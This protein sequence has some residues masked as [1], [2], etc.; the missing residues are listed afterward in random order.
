METG[1]KAGSDR[2]KQFIIAGPDEDQNPYVD[3]HSIGVETWTT[4]TPA[5]T[6]TYFYIKIHDDQG[7]PGN[8]ESVKMLFPDGFTEET[9]YLDYNDSDTC[10]IYRTHCFGTIQSGEYTFTAG[11]FF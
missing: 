8:F 5:V 11:V 2:D 6:F 4:D 1:N 7:V 3:L 10:G 9:L